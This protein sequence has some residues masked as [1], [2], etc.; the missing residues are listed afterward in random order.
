MNNYKTRKDTLKILGIHY[1]TLYKLAENKEI[2]TVKIGSRQ[3][4]NIDKYLKS[5][6]IEKEN[7]KIYVI[8]EYQVQNKKKI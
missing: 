4:Y 6:K 5:L 8:V 7:K 1:K 3:L 2:E